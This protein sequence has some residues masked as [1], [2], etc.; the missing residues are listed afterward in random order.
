M[1]KVCRF[2]K[3]WNAYEWTVKPQATCYW[4]NILTFTSSA[5][6]PWTRLVAL[7][8]PSSSSGAVASNVLRSNHDGMRNPALRVTGI[9]EAVGHITLTWGPLIAAIV[10]AQPW[11]QSKHLQ[12]YPNHKSWTLITQH[13]PSISETVK[14]YELQYQKKYS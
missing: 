14:K 13:S 1:A 6:N 10:L 4:R 8:M 2:V 9:V 11:L 12:L 5:I 7:T 3:N